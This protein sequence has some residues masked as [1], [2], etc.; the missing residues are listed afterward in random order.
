MRRAFSCHAE[1]VGLGWLPA[2]YIASDV[3]ARIECIRASDASVN[4]L[5]AFAYIPACTHITFAL[6]HG[7]KLDA[8][9]MPLY[10]QELQTVCITSAGATVT[11]A[12]LDSFL[13]ST[14]L[15]TPRAV[16]VVLDGVNIDGDVDAIP[17]DRFL[18]SHKPQ[19]LV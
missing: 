16:Q 15:P 18:V 8:P 2:A 11:A 9:S 14:F 13:D 7:G 4:I 10:A 12:E 5:T 3:L 17:R 6:T 19:A 1:Q